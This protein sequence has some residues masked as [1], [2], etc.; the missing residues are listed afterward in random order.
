MVYTN[1]VPQANQQIAATQKP[2][3]DNFAFLPLAIGQEHNF[4][5]T[6]PEKTYHLQASM[7]NLADPAPASPLPAGT[8]GMYYVNNGFPKFYD[9]ANPRFIQ[10]ADKSFLQRY[11]SLT[12][13]LVYPAG[14]Q[15]LTVP[16]QSC[17][18]VYAIGPNTATNPGYIFGQFVSTKGSINFTELDSHSMTTTSSGLNLQFFV[19]STSGNANGTYKFLIVYNTP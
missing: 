6:Y 16:D 8:D 7:P 12:A 15:T 11:V 17:G 13:A 18:T 1:N 10:L 3:L 2:I 14:T 19:T 5:S 9:G 4:D